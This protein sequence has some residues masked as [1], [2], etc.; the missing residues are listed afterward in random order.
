MEVFDQEWLITNGLGG[1]ASSSVSG[2]NTR[3]YH[4][5]LIASFK[6]PTERMVLVAKIEERVFYSKQYFD[7]STNQYP[8]IIYPNGTNYLKH[9]I[10]GTVPTWHY[11]AEEWE[12]KKQISMLQNSNT[13]VLTYTNTGKVPFFLE[14]HSLY[15]YTDYHATFHEKPEFGFYTEFESNHIKTFARNGAHPI[16]TKWSDGTYIEARSW[17]KNIQL[18]KSQSRGLEF[19]SDYY[20]IGFLKKEL[21]PNEEVIICFST[22]ESILEND[23]RKVWTGILKNNAKSVIKS[24]ST[25]YNDL[26]QS[27]DQFLVQRY[28]TKSQSIIAGYHWFT[29]WGRD[30][31]IAMR[32][33]T[34]AT[35]RQNRSKA[36]LATFYKS[37]DQGMLPVRFPDND[38][39]SLAYNAID[40]TLWLFIT[41]Y[42]YYVKFEDKT[43]IKEQLPA[44]KECIDW[45]IKG[46]RFNIRVTSEGFLYGGQEGEQLTWMD[47]LVDGKVITPRIGC[48]V[49]VNALW[50]N[51]LKIYEFFCKEL[52]IKVAK[53]FLTIRTNFESN[54][55]DYFINSEGTLFDVIIPNIASDNSFRPNQLFWC[56]L[57]FTVLTKNQ[58]KTIFDAVKEKLYTPYG[59][60]T[61]DTDDPAFIS[62]YEGDQWSRDHAYHQGTVWTYLLYDYYHAFLRNYG[63]TVKNRQQ[64]VNE[65]ADLKMHFY[66]HEGLHCISEIFDGLKPGEGKGCIQ[67]AWS[68]AALI[69]LYT[70]HKLYNL[71]EKE[72]AKNCN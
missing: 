37:L 28:S 49:E 20:R 27:G 69:K 29:D 64:V 17:Y 30:T 48:P 45:H 14:L 62:T 47:A 16:F 32:G 31:M 22:E 72:P 54:F 15:A 57:P 5:L 66:A 8:K 35:G 50:Y 11:A 65:L 25:F 40:A 70:D 71:A 55:S 52:K 21:Q 3:H 23:V 51:A 33:L 67:Q 1:Y 34:I 2:A 9:F 46:T 59:L 42:E 61:L 60:R 12:L 41:T 56:S 10:P 4:G 18:P 19:E 39:T 43:F 36:I 68:V 44:L 53:S 58:Q 6:P 63:D 38:D 24:R 13:T 7:L 26:I